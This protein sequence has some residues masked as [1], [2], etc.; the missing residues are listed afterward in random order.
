[1]ILHWNGRKWSATRVPV[2]TSHIQDIVALSASDAWATGDFEAGHSLVTVILHWNGKRWSSVRSVPGVVPQA[3]AFGA[4][5]DGWGAASDVS[6]RWNG[7]KWRQV[8]VPGPET[9]T[10]AGASAAGPSDVWM[11]GFFCPPAR[12][13]GTSDVIDTL[14]MRWNGR[15]WTRK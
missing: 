13:A 11:V 7:I 2:K 1:M 4:K 9:S 12:C 15:S 3:L 5:D 10:F 14:A 6:M 8:T